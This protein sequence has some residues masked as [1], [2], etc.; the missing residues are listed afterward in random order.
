[1]N[2]IICIVFYALY[3]IHCI[4][5][6]VFYAVYSMQ[7]ILLIVLYAFCYMYCDQCI[8]FYALYYMHCILCSAFYALFSMHCIQCI[9]LYAWYHMHCIQCIV[10]YA[11]YFS[12]SFLF[13]LIPLFKTTEEVFVLGFQS[14]KQLGGSPAFPHYFDSNPHK[15]SGT[16]TLLGMPSNS[17]GRHWKSSVSSIS[18]NFFRNIEVGKVFS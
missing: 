3:S 6:I 18:C 12:F 7:C 9:V 8:V 5:C 4:L 14:T 1:M 16:M 2:C 15:K 13:L 11:L 17:S 10:C